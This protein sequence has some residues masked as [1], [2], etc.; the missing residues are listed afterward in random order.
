MVRA[1]IEVVSKVAVLSGGVAWKCCPDFLVAQSR[2]IPHRN[3]TKS[4]KI[5]ENGESFRPRLRPVMNSD[6]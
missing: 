3:S 4:G 1:S 2:P 5:S 6:G